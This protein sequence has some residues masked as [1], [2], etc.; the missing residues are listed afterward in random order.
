MEQPLWR[1]WRLHQ[2]PCHASSRCQRHRRQG[3]DPM[4]DVLPPL[5]EA[6][7]HV[8]WLGTTR[9]AVSAGLH[10]RAQLLR[11]ALPGLLLDNSPCTS[12][13]P[14]CRLLCLPQT[15]GPETTLAGISSPSP[16]CSAPCRFN[17][18]I[19]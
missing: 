6:H 14:L 1:S 15:G 7:R 16:T 8:L 10:G 5:P 12:R 11:T 3:I 17:R 4:A 19:P 9:S 18:P 2:H 13:L